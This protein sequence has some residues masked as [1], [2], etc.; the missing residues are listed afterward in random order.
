[1]DTTI[2]APLLYGAATAWSAARRG[3]D[4][5]SESALIW[6]EADKIIRQQS[7]GRSSLDDFCKLFYGAQTAPTP[8]R[9]EDVVAAMNQ[10]QPYDWQTFFRDR[11]ESTS[12]Q[13]PLGGIEGSGWR[14][15]YTGEKP[16]LMDWASQT[17][18]VDLL[19]PE[20]EKSKFLDLQYSIGLLLSQDGTVRDSVPGMAGF[21]AGIIP[22]M[23]VL[24]V[25]G[26][27][28]SLAAME[29]AVE[30]SG[31]GG[32][33]NLTV[34]NGNFKLARHVDYHHGA[35]YPHLERDPSK[36]DLL[37][38]IIVPRTRAQSAEINH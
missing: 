22:G 32:Q 21:N 25:N 2:S 29:S 20:W 18:K 36:P 6:L 4:F 23:Q 8:Y 10:I 38:N 5:Y 9:F 19:W 1:M 35:R 15:V 30:A 3:T 26:A 24:T 17:N 12:A 31:S 34:A 37:T 11:L 7:K 16:Q 14:L 28:F 13:P 27:P 33:L